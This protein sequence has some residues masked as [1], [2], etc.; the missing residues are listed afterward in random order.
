MDVYKLLLLLCRYEAA[1]KTD[2]VIENVE[3]ECLSG[4]K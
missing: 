2:S 4:D 3:D 1:G